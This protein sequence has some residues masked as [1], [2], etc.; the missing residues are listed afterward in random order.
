[1]KYDTVSKLFSII[2]L[3]LILFSSKAK[4][5]YQSPALADFFSEFKVAVESQDLDKISEFY[6]NDQADFVTQER[7]KW[8]N[9][10]SAVSVRDLE[11]SYFSLVRNEDSEI[12]MFDIKSGEPLFDLLFSSF[13]APYPYLLKRFDYDWK[14]FNR[15]SLDKFYV[16]TGEKIDVK[17]NPQLSEINVSQ[18]IKLKPLRESISSLIFLLSDEMN[19]QVCT[20]NG[21]EIPFER[22]GYLLK[23]DTPLSSKKGMKVVNITYTGKVHKYKKWNNHYI[24]NNGG[25]LRNENYWYV[26]LSSLEN[27]I[28]RPVSLQIDIPS[29]FYAVA[30]NGNLVSAEKN[31]DRF[32]QKW[33]ISSSESQ[34]L[35]F[36]FCNNWKIKEF[37]TDINKLIICLKKDSSLKEKELVKEVEQITKTYQD[38]FGRIKASNLH[39]LDYD[40]SFNRKNY[41]P[42]NRTILP[43]ELAHCWWSFPKDHWLTEGF[44]EYA[45]ALYIERSK[46]ES[47]FVN[48]L[49]FL[50]DKMMKT[51]ENGVGLPM[52]GSGYHPLLYSKGTLIVHTLRRELGDA[53][54]FKI[55]PTFI[56]ELYGKNATW[57]DFK[58]VAEDISGK[59]LKYLFEQWLLRPG[60]PHLELSYEILADGNQNVVKGNVMQEKPHYKLPVQ[61]IIS[62]EEMQEN[63]NLFL[64]GEE[65]IFEYPVLFEPEYV[66]LEIDDGIPCIISGEG[67]NAKLSSL[68]KV[69]IRA[70]ENHA[71][72]EAL[73]NSEK[74]LMLTKEDEEIALIHF[75]IGKA[76]FG[77]GLYS[78]A[79]ENLNRAKSISALPENYRNACILLLG[80]A[81]LCEGKTQ[82][83]KD[84]F[85]Q[86]IDQP[87]IPAYYKTEA[88]RFINYSRVIKPLPANIVQLI[89]QIQHA[90]N[91]SNHTEI[92]ALCR[93]L[94]EEKR[95][96]MDIPIDNLNLKV[97]L[98][99]NGKTNEYYI[100]CFAT[101]T[102]G[103]QNIK[104]DFVLLAEEINDKIVIKDIIRIQLN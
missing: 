85:N 42:A 49:K 44:A 87:E 55:L 59:S 73:Q 83:A 77:L 11:I 97:E 70:L 89:K 91:K 80:K 37:D 21:K 3:P 98:V 81:K 23:I 28:S 56:S 33:E 51:M 20:E 96:F 4:C 104:G 86:L 8:E 47:M 1:M 25:I 90:I 65:V 50:N 19:V 5:P 99:L 92:A 63:H 22:F 84:L 2:L 48:K 43:H 53:V 46:D 7:N 26:S 34:F 41:I 31:N 45:D 36:I 71:F 62:G 61:I 27:Y 78:E 79:V 57:K 12:I 101:G 67:L 102:L 13:F 32:I 75:R 82:E 76:V 54:F 14:F 66:D 30:D 68:E 52:V 95:S 10:L 69:G 35:G 74:L 18:T 58:T 103:K 24:E 60:L 38:I 93:Y 15:T 9:I 39:I 72:K 40:F 100:E 94:P 29:D 6:S 16:S 17:V 64:D 88:S